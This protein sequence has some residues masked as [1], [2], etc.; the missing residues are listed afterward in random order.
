MK[1][2]RIAPPGRLDLDEIYVYIAR[3][4]PSAASRWLKKTMERFSWLARNP[5]SGETR[6]E[7]RP[8]LRCIA[9]GRYVIYF[10]KRAGHLEI[11]RVL[12]GARG[13][14]GLL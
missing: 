14:T 4:N 2:F 7:V 12:H 9:H 3:D 13:H 10:R 6:D 5:D 8:G 11:V 1:R